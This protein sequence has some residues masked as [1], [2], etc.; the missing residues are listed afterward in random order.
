MLRRSTFCRQ[1]MLISVRCLFGFR[2][3]H[4]ICLVASQA[5][6]EIVLRAY[7]RSYQQALLFSIIR[8]ASTGISTSG[9]F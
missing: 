8:I 7:F 2:F 5:Y 1:R 9:N 6:I 3:I 4:I